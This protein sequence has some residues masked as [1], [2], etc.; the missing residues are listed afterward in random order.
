VG[1]R[2]ASFA[3][4]EVPNFPPSLDRIP[5]QVPSSSAR[6][7]EQLKEKAIGSTAVPCACFERDDNPI[8]SID[9]PFCLIVEVGAYF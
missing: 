6:V 1:T 7:G 2:A 3:S 4:V 8:A 9:I 5:R